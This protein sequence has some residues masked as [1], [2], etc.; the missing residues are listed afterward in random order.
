MI[1]TASAAPTIPGPRVI[2]EFLHE[3]LPSIKSGLEEFYRFSSLALGWL[4]LLPEVKVTGLKR[5][6]QR[7][8]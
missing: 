1:L 2:L 8:R 6:L 7:L 5:T 3:I 4:C